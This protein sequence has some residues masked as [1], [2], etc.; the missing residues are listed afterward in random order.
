MGSLLHSVYCMDTR[1][2]TAYLSANKMGSWLT[3]A[4]CKHSR[5]LKDSCCR[6]TAVVVYIKTEA[7]MH[8]TGRCWKHFTKA[9][10]DDMSLVW[11][12][13]PGNGLLRSTGL[14]LTCWCRCSWSMDG[15]GRPSRYTSPL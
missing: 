14:Q 13:G 6:P 12:Q 8:P 4:T 9:Q 5:L 3:M 7:C 2:L 11:V 10:G 1:R 15:R